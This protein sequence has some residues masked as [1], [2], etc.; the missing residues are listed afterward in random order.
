MVIHLPPTCL[1]IF[2]L[3]GLHCSSAS[4]RNLSFFLQVE[5]VSH[6]DNLR[7]FVQKSEDLE[8][9]CLMKAIKSYCE[10]RVLPYGTHKTVVFWYPQSQKK[11]SHMILHTSKVIHTYHSLRF[12]IFHSLHVHCLVF[13]KS[14]TSSLEIKGFNWNQSFSFP[15]VFLYIAMVPTT[16]CDHLNNM[17]VLYPKVLWGLQRLRLYIAS[18]FFSFANISSQQQK[19]CIYNQRYIHRILNHLWLVRLRD[20]SEHLAASKQFT[21]RRRDCT[22]ST[23]LCLWTLF[24]H[25]N[26]KSPCPV[27]RPK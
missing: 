16:W 7:S 4:V 2:S 21:W 3:E 15:F 18:F 14:E 1:F 22:P 13:S 23:H 6:R 19:M 17:L 9:K 12:L 27:F 10:L 25:L 5:R 11:K 26:S 24:L 20:P 8:K